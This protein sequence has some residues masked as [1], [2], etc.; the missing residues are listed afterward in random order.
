MNDIMLL[1]C[2]PK[3]IPDSDIEGVI[4]RDI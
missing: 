2:N 3:C 1:T 4:P